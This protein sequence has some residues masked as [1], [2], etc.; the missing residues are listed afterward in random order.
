MPDG[1]FG[2][3]DE[4]RKLDGLEDVE[5]QAAERALQ[6]VGGS[7]G[8]YEVLTGVKKGFGDGVGPVLSVAPSAC[9]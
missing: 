8:A 4:D 1:L 9:C 7:L 5:G 3:G 2:A 6:P